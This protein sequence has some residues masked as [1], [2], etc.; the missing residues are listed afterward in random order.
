MIGARRV[1]GVRVDDVTPQETID[2][3]RR[4]IAERRP[5]QIVTVNPEFVMLARRLPA[6]AAV[7]DAADLAVP[8]GTGIAWACKRAGLP[9]RSLVRGVELVEALAAAAAR[10][11]WRVFLLGAREGVAAEAAAA[12]QRRFPGLKVVGT[13][14]GRASQDGDAE[15]TAAVR[16]ASPVDLLL[17]AYGAPAQDLWIARNAADLGVPVAIGVGGSF[18]YLS[19]RIRRA[20]RWAIQLGLE[21]LVRLIRQPWR[22]RRQLALVSFVWLVL[23]RRR[24][25]RLI[26]RQ[27]D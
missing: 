26:A 10:E 2:F 19:G 22:W 27:I 9:I 5:R 14:A 4:F 6:F 21:W 13:Y 16:S 7:L 24:P 3:V 11:G 17:V 15:T 18:D 12:L 23:S 25:V 1:L 20:P 8:D